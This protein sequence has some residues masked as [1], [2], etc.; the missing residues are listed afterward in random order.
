MQSDMTHRFLVPMDDS[1]QSR[2]ALRYALETFADAELTAVH[3]ID[4]VEAGYGGERDDVGHASNWRET[5]GTEAEELFEA[6][7]ELAAEYDTSLTATVA[8]GQPAD[9]IVEVAEEGAFDGVVM[10][11][12]GRSGVSRVLLGSVAETVVRRSPVPVTVVR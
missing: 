2:S 9:A 3:V 8:E 6:A 11:S 12:Q 4:P 10:G 7:A 5:S 1:A